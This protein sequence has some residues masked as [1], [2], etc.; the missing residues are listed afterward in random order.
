[1]ATFGARESLQFVQRCLGVG[2]IGLWSLVA[3]AHPDPNPIPLG[4]QRVP[5]RV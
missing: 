3:H 1:M 5:Q 2:I 4:S